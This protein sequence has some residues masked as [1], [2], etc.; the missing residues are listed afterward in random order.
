MSELGRCTNA[1]ASFPL[2]PETRPIDSPPYRANPRAKA[3]IDECVH[4]MLELGII[5][6]RPSLWG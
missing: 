2:P 4:D 5:E 6:E 1:E 3:V